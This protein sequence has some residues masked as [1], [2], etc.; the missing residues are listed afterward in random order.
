VAAQLRKEGIEV[1]V[2]EEGSR[3]VGAFIL[4]AI[5]AEHQPIL[6]DSLPCNTA[7]L[8]D[9][10]VLNVGDSFDPALLAHKGVEVLV[11]PV[12]APYLT[13]LIAYDFGRRMEPRA[14]VPV[15][16]GY[17]RDAFVKG[18]YDTYETFFGKVGIRFH[19]LEAPGASVEL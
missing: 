9:E 8:V 7:F 15:H 11:L 16:D 12:M 1:T 14:V 6:A 5:P 3:T 19:R 2:Q 13:E 4:L 17:A 10:R 18:R